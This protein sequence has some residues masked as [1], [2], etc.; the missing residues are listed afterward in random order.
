M[1]LK[2][3]LCVGHM[4][5]YSYHRNRY[6]LVNEISYGLAQ[7]EPIQRRPLYLYLPTD[8]IKN[9]YQAIEKLDLSK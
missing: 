1:S 3:I 2:T 7:S 8:E 5:G 6:H 9:N 4:F